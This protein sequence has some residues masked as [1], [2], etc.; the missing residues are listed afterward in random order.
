[1]RPFEVLPE[2]RLDTYL[3]FATFLKMRCIESSKNAF[4]IK[5]DIFKNLMWYTLADSNK[6]YPV[7][8]ERVK[9]IKQLNAQGVIP[10]ELEAMDASTP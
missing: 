5:K 2:L 8:I 4:L 7:T 10:D 9:K 6:Q 3:I 1:M